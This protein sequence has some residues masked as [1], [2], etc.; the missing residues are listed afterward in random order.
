MKAQQVL[1]G[2]LLALLP[3]CSSSFPST[4]EPST[5]NA[6]QSIASEASPS[7]S[8]APALTL[9]AAPAVSFSGSSSKH[10]AAFAVGSPLKVDYTHSGT[11][12]FIVDLTNPATEDLASITNLIGKATGTTWVYGASGNAYFDV[13]ADG[14]WTLTGTAELP[15]IAPLPVTL[16][17]TTNAVTAPF[18]VAGDVTVR[19][20]HAGTGNFIVGLIDATDASLA[21]S[22]SNVIGEASD[23]TVL[24][25]HSGIFAFDVTADGAWSL[26]VTPN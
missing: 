11:G 24:Y 1:V 7:P 8:A 16:Q 6:G 13:L 2:A 26:E 4:S 15:P 19:W 23:E 22:V 5:T 14:P 12:N 17:G 9:V 20:T 10:T 3:A 18:L 25:G 21:D